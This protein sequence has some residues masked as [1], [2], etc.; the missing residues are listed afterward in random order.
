MRN[1]M[2]G[3]STSAK[4]F[5]LHIKICELEGLVVT[6]VPNKDNYKVQVHIKLGVPRRGY[7]PRIAVKKDR[8]SEQCI[9]QDG[10]VCW[11]ESFEQLCNL[12]AKSP[13][14][15]SWKI[16]LEVHG[17]NVESNHKAHILAIVKLDVTELTSGSQ[18]PIKLPI[19]C[20]IGDVTRD[21]SLKVKLDI[22]EVQKLCT[23][24]TV[25]PL[26]PTHLL[27]SLLSCVNFQN[28]KQT[29]NKM[30]T[31]NSESDTDEESDT[32][33]QRMKTVNLLRSQSL[34]ESAAFSKQG[35]EQ[36][37][38]YDDVKPAKLTRLLSWNIGKKKHRDVP[39]LNKAYGEGGDDI[40]NAR[41]T[42]IPYVKPEPD[43]VKSELKRIEFA[44]SDRFEV[45]KWE[46]KRVKSRDGKL[47]LQ[48][49][50][51]LATIDQRSEKALGGG[52]C[53]VIATVITDWLHENPNTLPLKCEFDKLIR[54]GSR[55]WRNLC[56]DESHKDKFL[57]QHFDLDTVIQA[58][59][60][61]LKVVSEK[62]Y[63]GFFKLETEN[64][65]ECLQ[66]A[67][68]FDSIW[69]KLYNGESNSE[70]VY[71]VSWND[72]FFVLKKEKD[73]MYIIDTLGER[74][75]E[76]CDKAYIL[77]FNEDSMIY[78][79]KMQ[80]NSTRVE[81]EER[82]DEDGNNCE[83]V[84]KGTS[85]CK[86]FIKGFLAAVPLGELQS[87]VEKGING[88]VPLH[89]LLQIEFQYMSPLQQNS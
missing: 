73:M 13:G 35:T 54:D 37:S 83:Y 65:L 59:V 69:D 26:S 70:G 71:I 3:L 78:D 49:E 63:V 60:R 16:N 23:K 76:G 44:G 68:S 57:D 51:F 34:H 30:E 24:N 48:T 82:K 12:D 38:S 6:D 11:N 61:P 55:E 40:D 21:A 27:P 2:F 56:E 4:H 5:K 88:N 58:Q 64:E 62:S 43:S 74:L 15:S 46:K 39:L 85:C 20:C 80:T 41:R 72:H 81:S 28:E 33:Y 10:R 25:Y 8:T 45:G 79:V 31:E 84:C 14:P 89:Q 66:E 87:N 50:I 67:M 17:I 18:K 75:A 47:E 7:I 36:T 1:W 77:K 42:L 19:R 53:T 86:E 9:N 52:A 29:G 32:S 22:V